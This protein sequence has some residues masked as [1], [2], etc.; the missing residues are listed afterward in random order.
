MT[1]A[2]QQTSAT[3]SMPSIYKRET[4]LINGKMLEVDY[5]DSRDR[6]EGR[7]TVKLRKLTPLVMYDGKLVGKGWSVWD[8]AA[9]ANHIKVPE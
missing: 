1:I 2:A 4:Y 8:S 7:D 9:K 3:D 5:F 6:K